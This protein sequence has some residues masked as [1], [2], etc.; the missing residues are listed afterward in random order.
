MCV[1]AWMT[2]ALPLPTRLAVTAQ[3]KSTEA[4][5]PGSGAD[6]DA[7]AADA[8]PSDPESDSSSDSSRDSGEDES[9]LPSLTPTGPSSPDSSGHESNSSGESSPPPLVPPPS[10]GRQASPPSP[11]ISTSLASAAE[12]SP[13]PGSPSVSPSP[14]PNTRAPIAATRGSMKV[15]PVAAP[16]GGRLSLTPDKGPLA[17]HGGGLSLMSAEHRALLDGP[18]GPHLGGVAFGDGGEGTAA[19]PSLMAPAPRP[20]PAALPALAPA[21][22]PTSPSIS[23]PAPISSPILDPGPHLELSSDSDS[24]GDDILHPKPYNHPETPLK[25]AT[26]LPPV[27]AKRMSWRQASQDRVLSPDIHPVAA[28]P[29]PKAD[30]GALLRTRMDLPKLGSLSPATSPVSMAGP[31]AQSDVLPALLAPTRAAALP[32]V[33]EHGSDADSSDIDEAE[34][35]PAKTR[36]APMNLL[37]DPDG[38]GPAAIFDSAGKHA[39]KPNQKKEGTAQEYADSSGVEDDSSDASDG[40]GSYSSQSAAEN[41]VG[42]AASD[43]E[44]DG[45]DHI[46]GDAAG[47]PGNDKHAAKTDLAEAVSP[48]N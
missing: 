33:T 26:T 12:L 10:K 17:P 30:R 15:P 44:T 5:S 23:A 19:L 45:D 11:D 48:P 46:P 21:T 8:P 34:A 31:A 37:V 3:V 43:A 13:I 16:R 28:T 35:S 42:E 4:L 40:D 25:R 24:S 36:A 18:S 29:T 9:D 14:S 47:K 27:S 41:G 39:S 1:L 22:T 38:A 32:F 2:N 7:A 6:G 20:E